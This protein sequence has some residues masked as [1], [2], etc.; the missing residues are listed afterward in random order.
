ML[1][2]AEIVRVPLLF[3]EIVHVPISRVLQTKGS[4]I[5]TV[6][7]GTSICDAVG[8]MNDRHIGSLI[9]T[10]G[11][12]VVGI[13]TERDILTRI[14]ACNRDPMNTL[15]ED[16]MTRDLVVIDPD[17]TIAEVMMLFTDRHCRHFPVI[18]HGALLGL[19]SSGDVTS[20]L[21]RDQERTITDLYEYITR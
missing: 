5:E 2:L 17:T 8:Q 3:D 19:I 20:W 14:V 10:D 9:V 15:V 13:L 4:H 16:V 7:L 12:L 11:D 6:Q 21:V 1:G 18:R